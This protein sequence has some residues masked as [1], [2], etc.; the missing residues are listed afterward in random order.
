MLNIII[1]MIIGIVITLV[2]VRIKYYLEVNHLIMN[3]K[4]LFI[5]LII[6]CLILYLIYCLIGLIFGTSYTKPNGNVCR[7]YKYGIKVCTGNINIE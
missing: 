1:G 7:G 3:W 4:K 5:A 2:I 6:V